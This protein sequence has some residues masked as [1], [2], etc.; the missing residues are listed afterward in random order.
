[1]KYVFR[2]S[3]LLALALSSVKGQTSI[4]LNNTKGCVGTAVSGS[5]YATVGIP[6]TIGTVPF[7]VMTCVVLDSAGF[8][9]DTTTTP[10]TLR[11]LAAT[12][13]VGPK[14]YAEVPAGTVNSANTLF[15]LSN[16]PASGYPVQVYRNGVLLMLCSSSTTAC[17]GDYTL[18]GS[19]ITF[20]TTSQTASGQSQIPQTS[21]LLQVV[22]WH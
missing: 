17:N 7:V 15:T 21:D 19:V 18:T 9:L 22:Y 20:L 11:V 10:P 6:T 4:T 3:I 12:A 14:Q 5:V 2:F 8:K 1:M 13:T 16:Q